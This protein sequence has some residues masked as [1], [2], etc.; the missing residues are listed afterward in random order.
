[1][2]EATGNLVNGVTTGVGDGVTKLG[3]GDLLGT[4]GAIGGGLQQGV[5]GLAT[6]IAGYGRNHESDEAFFDMDFGDKVRDI[7]GWEKK[8]KK[9]FEEEGDK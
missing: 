5:G 9:K 7:V 1:L 6:G 3:R 8:E 2:G 4:V